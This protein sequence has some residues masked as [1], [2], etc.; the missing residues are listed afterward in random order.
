MLIWRIFLVDL[1]RFLKFPDSGSDTNEADNLPAQN[2][3]VQ[4]DS[5]LIN[6]PVY[7]QT[8]SLNW[9]TGYEKHIYFADTVTM[10]FF[11]GLWS[12]FS[13]VQF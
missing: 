3:P 7:S 2:F 10:P 13:L 1:P 8:V 6:Y 9:S 12:S 4:N 11:P 5:A